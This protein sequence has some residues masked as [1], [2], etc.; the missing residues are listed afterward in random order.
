MKS[1][2]PGLIIIE[3]LSF[4]FLIFLLS[5][6]SISENKEIFEKDLTNQWDTIRP[7]ENPDK[8]WY[9]HMLDDGTGKYLIKNEKVFHD[10]PGMDHLYLR[11]AWAYLEPEEGVY[12]WTVID[13]IIDKYVP[14]GYGISFRVTCKE[15]GPAPTS[16]PY[17]INGVGY[18]TPVWVKEAGANGVV[19]ENAA[20][21]WT[22]DWDDPVFLEK[23]SN[24][25]K[26]FAA[27]YDGKPWLRYIDIGSIGDWGEGHTSSSTNIAPTKEEVKTHIDLHRKYYKNSQLV[28]TDDL[29]FFKKP[30]SVVNNLMEYALQNDISFR[31]DSPFNKYWLTS[32]KET[33]SVRHPEFFEAAYK[34]MPT[35]LET[36]HYINIKN[37]GFWKEKN[38]KAI[39]P[40]IGYTGEKVF[41]N[42]IKT[43]HATYIGFHGYVEDWYGD[44]PELAKE[45]LNLCGYWYFPKKLKI[46]TTKDNELSFH[47]EWLNK[48]V[49]PAYNV[50]KLKGKL[51]ETNDPTK[52]TFFEMENSGNLKWMPNDAVETSYT[53]K[54]SEKLEGNYSLY[55]QLFDERSK[56]LVDIG[57]KEELKKN[58]YFLISIFKI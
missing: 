1:Q 36:A 34:T 51:V 42:V 48:G 32:Q 45:M 23:L 17:E 28:A 58:D 22:P 18:A 11:L 29:I 9:H 37:W 4:T 3:L 56:R 2:N 20:S 43:M 38:G 47:I 15:T 13:S 16:V 52:V 35:V 57:L 54:S 44:N 41:R 21:V 14:R 10:F 33:W 26:A 39:I 8:G 46:E 6:C 49:A 5:S 31:D 24:F 7:I 53:V 40:E 25:H 12:N 30:D 27:R 19:P 50:Y 55:I